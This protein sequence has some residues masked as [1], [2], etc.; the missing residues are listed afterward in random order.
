MK[1]FVCTVCGY[2][3]EGESAPDECPICHQ[4]A[5]KFR[6]ESSPE[7]GDTSGPE[8]EKRL[9]RHTR[10]QTLRRGTQLLHVDAHRSVVKGAD[11]RAVG[12]AEVETDIRTAG[13]IR[14]APRFPGDVRHVRQT[15]LLPDR[16][17]QES[18]GEI[19][20]P[21]LG[22]QGGIDD[23]VHG[24]LLTAEICLTEMHR[25]GKIGTAPGKGRGAA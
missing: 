15:Q 22:T 17:G 11:G 5:E 24:C 12:V 25:R 16:Q 21:A 9:V 3:Y 7:G 2:V 4:P 19:A 23:E 13:E 6:E 14:L 10:C 1:K 18:A 20:F 8:A